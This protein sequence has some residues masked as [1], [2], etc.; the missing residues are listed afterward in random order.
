[1]QKTIK[2]ERKT[3]KNW[4]ATVCYPWSRILPIN[5]TMPKVE[6]VIPCHY[7]IP[8]NYYL[9]PDITQI[10][11]QFRL[12]KTWPLAPCRDRRYGG[13]KDLL[14]VKKNPACRPAARHYCSI[15]LFHHS[16]VTAGWS[17]A[18]YL[19]LIY[20]GCFWIRAISHQRS[21]FSKKL[22]NPVG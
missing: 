19:V 4:A 7:Y 10:S 3:L 8:W 14:L 13:S 20:K 9:F 15:P 17:E 1:M 11:H 5:D 16:P 21:A 6:T 18:N 22:V 2:N 12:P